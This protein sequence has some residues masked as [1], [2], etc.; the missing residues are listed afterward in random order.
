M[1]SPSPEDE[2]AFRSSRARG[3]VAKS[4]IPAKAGIHRAIARAAEGWVP[5]CPTDQVRGLK[6]HGTTI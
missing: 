3:N 5:A 2:L 1:P 6:A 4:V